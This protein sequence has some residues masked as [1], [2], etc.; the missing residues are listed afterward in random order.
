MSIDLPERPTPNERAL[1]QWTRERQTGLSTTALTLTRTP[2]DGMEL[3]WKNGALLDPG[4]D[5]TITNAQVTLNVAA[6]AGDVFVCHYLARS[7]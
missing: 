3:L 7:T 6:I 2:V 5:Y 1:S 4:T